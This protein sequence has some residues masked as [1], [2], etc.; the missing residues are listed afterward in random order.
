MEWRQPPC[1]EGGSE[2]Y[3]GCSCDGALHLRAESNRELADMV[4]R[5]TKD[6]EHALE[7]ETDEAEVERVLRIHRE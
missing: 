2:K 3:E 5:V 6:V 4:D 7:G 1:R